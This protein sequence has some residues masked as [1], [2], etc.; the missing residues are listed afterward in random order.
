MPPSFPA[1]FRRQEILLSLPLPLGKLAARPLYLAASSKFTKN[2]S[3][4]NLAR[5]CRANNLSVFIPSAHGSFLLST[6]PNFSPKEEHFLTLLMP[7]FLKRFLR[8]L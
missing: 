3:R 6:Y 8:G 1:L 7:P 4:K 5:Y 2:G